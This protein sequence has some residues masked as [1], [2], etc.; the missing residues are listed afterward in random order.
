M[1]GPPFFLGN[2]E[3]R[4]WL[5][6]AGPSLGSATVKDEGAG[7]VEVLGHS[8]LTKRRESEQSGPS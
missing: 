3:Q 6:A 7:W 5:I 4:G 1:F 2:G 8:K